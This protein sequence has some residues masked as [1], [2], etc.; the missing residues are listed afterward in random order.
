MGDKKIY[1]TSAES[2]QQTH[3]VHSCKQNTKATMPFGLD[4]VIAFNNTCPTDERVTEYFSKCATVRARV[5]E[6]RQCSTVK[7]EVK[8]KEKKS[9]NGEQRI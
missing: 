3:L 9:R 7:A 8:K 5:R 2:N 4:I 1:C 6:R